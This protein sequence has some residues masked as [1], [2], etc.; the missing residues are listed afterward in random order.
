MSKI[1]IV[2]DDATTVK[3]LRFLM[4]NK[5]HEV[6]CCGNGQEALE[7]VKDV[8]PDLILMDVM[9]PGVNGFE[10][11][12]RIKKDP[13]TSGITIVILSA[14]GQEMEVMKGLQSGA[15]AYVVKPFDSAA[16]LRIIEDK[17]ADAR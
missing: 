9:M 2:E 5:K 13:A 10:V 17:L 16:L 7:I 11:T 4:E 8:M 3:L 12:K 1:M 6:V 14:L 15:D